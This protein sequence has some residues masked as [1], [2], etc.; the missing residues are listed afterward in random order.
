MSRDEKGSVDDM[1]IG[2]GGRAWTQDFN[3]VLTPRDHGGYV[4]KRTSEEVQAR[5]EMRPPPGGGRDEMRMDNRRA[6]S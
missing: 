6:G 4:R 3:S 1:Q 2:K 5:D